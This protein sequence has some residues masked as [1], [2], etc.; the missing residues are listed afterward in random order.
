MLPA[1]LE[2]DQVSAVYDRLA[3]VYDLWA[4]ISETRARDLCLELAAIRDGELVLEVAVGTGLGFAEIL[5]RNPTGENVGID[6]ALRM[7]TRAQARAEA[8][9][10]VNFTLRQ[11]DAY[12]LDFPDERFDLLVNNYLFDLL[13][14][15]DFVNVLS[16]FKR[17]LRPGGRLAMV[18]MTSAARWWQ[19]VWS[20]LYRINPSWLGGCRGVELSPFL[21][22]A[23]FDV[24]RRE[25]VSQM[26]FPSEVVLARRP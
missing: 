11:G 19:R 9:G 25:R 10:Q 8:T 7:L 14:Q 2:K 16:G 20:V 26:S 21:V 3:P 5:T 15:D 13:P 6:L 22:E 23:G 18:N 1:R 24:L 17:V 4:R 12:R